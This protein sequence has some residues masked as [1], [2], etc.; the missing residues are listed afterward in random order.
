MAMRIFSIHAHPDD[1]EILAGGTLALLAGQGHSITI[2]TLTNGD[3]GSAEYSAEEL[4]RI[5]QGEARAAASVIGADY[6]WGGFRD[7]CVYSDD[8]SRRRVTSLIR[9]FRPDIVLAASPVDYHCDH[10][11]ASRL[12]QDAC[13]AASCPNYDTSAFDPAP[14]TELI[15]HL[16]FVDPT[17]GIDRNQQPVAPQFVV[18]VTSVLETKR[19][20]LACHETQRSWLKR[21]HGMEQ[22]TR[23]RGALADIAAG[24]GFRQYAGHPYPRTELLQELLGNAVHQIL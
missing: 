18:D 19:K 10:E 11:G 8:T 4:G 23:A 7:L 24:E 16:Y 2:V 21:Q 12:V 9:R 3:C 1:A 20:M 5:R 15:P 22:W 17:E 14:A 6:A 13:F